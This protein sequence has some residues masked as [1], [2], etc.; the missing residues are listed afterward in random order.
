MK[1]HILLDERVAQG[2]NAFAEL[3]VVRVPKSV[4][5]SSHQFKYSLS[6][7]SENVC[8]FRFDNEAGKGDHYH[9]GSSE[10]PYKFSTMPALLNDFWKMV[11]EW[12]QPK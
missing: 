1:A 10:L 2:I 3:R 11:D 6:L 7:I 8:V 9:L 5:G 4:R 12:R